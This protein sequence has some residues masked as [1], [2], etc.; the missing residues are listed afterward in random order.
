M[1]STACGFCCTGWKNAPLRYIVNRSTLM[2]Y[3]FPIMTVKSLAPAWSCLAKA[4]TVCSGI[5]P[6]YTPEQLTG[7]K[8]VLVANLKPAKL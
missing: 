7:H 4:R 8:I 2:R 6:W 1:P 5:A 3:F